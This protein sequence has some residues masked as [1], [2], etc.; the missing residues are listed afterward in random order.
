MAQ[1]V[2]GEI[3]RDIWK[4]GGGTVP[5]L[6]EYWMVELMDGWID[7]CMDGWKDGKIDGQATNWNG[8]VWQ[9]YACLS[10]FY[11]LPNPLPPA[12]HALEY[13]SNSK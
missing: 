6:M 10:L 1:L 7:R 4:K 3:D 2:E 9:I 13:A 12:S 11:L 5:G 8:N